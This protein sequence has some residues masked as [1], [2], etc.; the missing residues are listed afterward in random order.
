MFCFFFLNRLSGETEVGEDKTSL[1]PNHLSH[2]RLK[3]TKLLN[4][5]ILFFKKMTTNP[6][7]PT[8]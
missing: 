1:V 5:K 7:H 6:P 8:L 2:F 3:P 4:P